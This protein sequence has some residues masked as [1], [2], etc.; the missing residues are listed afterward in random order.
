MH[1]GKHPETKESG[2]GIF[3]SL[4][5]QL[6]PFLFLF[7]QDNLIWQDF[8]LDAEATVH[9]KSLKYWQKGQYCPWNEGNFRLDYLPLVEGLQGFHWSKHCSDSSCDAFLILELSTGSDLNTP[10]SQIMHS[11]VLKHWTS[12][13]KRG[14]GVNFPSGLVIRNLD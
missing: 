11:K 13:E 5:R 6:L 9:V 12:L 3:M 14:E 2:F 10:H 1:K 7:E 8:Y 4:S